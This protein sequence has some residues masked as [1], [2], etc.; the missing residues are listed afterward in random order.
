ME[1]YYNPNHLLKTVLSGLYPGSMQQC[2]VRIC[3][4]KML[5]FSRHS[6]RSDKLSVKNDKHG[7]F[8]DP[9]RRSVRASSS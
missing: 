3:V 9:I 7:S 8:C 1:C 6:Y 4:F 2:E 5:Y